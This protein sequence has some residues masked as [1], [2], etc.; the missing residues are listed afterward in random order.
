MV[1]ESKL[2]TLQSIKENLPL[3]QMSYWGMHI[4]PYIRHKQRRC[5]G[6]SDFWLSLWLKKKI[7][8]KY[9]WITASEV[10]VSVQQPIRHSYDEDNAIWWTLFF[11]VLHIYFLHVSYLRLFFFTVK[12]YCN[13]VTK[14]DIYLIISPWRKFL[15]SQ[16]IC[17]IRKINILH[18]F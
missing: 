5:W 1:N 3:L 11:T 12:M 17:E 2:K 14:K 18:M 15:Q 16:K 4:L 6:S 10:E 9:F 13:Q 8:L 7:T